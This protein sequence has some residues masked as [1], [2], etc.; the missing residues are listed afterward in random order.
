MTIQEDKRPSNHGVDQP[1]AIDVDDGTIYWE[2]FTSTKGLTY[3]VGR[4]ISDTTEADSDKVVINSEKDFG[5]VVNW[6]VGDK[7]WKDTQR[8]DIGITQYT[9]HSSSSPIYDYVLEIKNSETYNFHFYDMTGD[10]YQINAYEKGEHLVRLNSEQ[11]TI[12]FITG[13]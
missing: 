7:E 1:Q 12:L 3:E 4:K 9:Y 11:P 6:Q 10:S 8:S 13:S 5:V 2:Q